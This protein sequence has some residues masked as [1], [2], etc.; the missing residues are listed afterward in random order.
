[1]LSS[2][3]E[4]GVA[5]YITEFSMLGWWSITD[6]KS[7]GGNAKSQ[8]YLPLACDMFICGVESILSPTGAL[9]EILLDID[10]D[11]ES[12]LSTKNTFT[13]SLIIVFV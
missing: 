13:I 4:Q 11:D 7:I 5:I 9:L 8:G 10:N 3:F 1:M 6:K 12:T 2:A